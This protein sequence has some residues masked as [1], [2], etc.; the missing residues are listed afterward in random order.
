M[1]TNKQWGVVQNLIVEADTKNA[2]SSALDI[3]FQEVSKVVGYK[4]FVTDDGIPT[5]A[6]YWSGDNLNKFIVEIKDPEDIVDM[7]LTWAKNKSENVSY[8]D[9]DGSVKAGFKIF[10]NMS[11]D[12][13]PHD[14][15]YIAFYMQPSWIEY[16]K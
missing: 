2:L 7:L 8:P 11:Y 13:A 12:K 4:E 10:N 15:F 5:L 3:L 9:I 16:H 1:N 14:R 6:V